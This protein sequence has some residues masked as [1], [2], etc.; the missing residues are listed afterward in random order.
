MRNVIVTGIVPCARRCVVRGLKRATVLKKT[1]LRPQIRN[2]RHSRRKERLL[3]KVRK[4]RGETGD[5]PSDPQKRVQCMPDGDARSLHSFLYA[6]Q[7]LSSQ[8]VRSLS[9]L[10]FLQFEGKPLCCFTDYVSER[11]ILRVVWWPS[12]YFHYACYDNIVIRSVSIMWKFESLRAWFD[13]SKFFKESWILKVFDRRRNYRVSS[14]KIA[15]E[16]MVFLNKHEYFNCDV[17]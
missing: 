16:I 14:I 7:L 2:E 12:I 9:I 10:E 5:H 11:E 3:H 15:N 1:R 13:F 4:R 17:N 6:R 8:L